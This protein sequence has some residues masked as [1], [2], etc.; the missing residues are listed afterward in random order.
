MNKHVIRYTLGKMIR[1]EGL[2]M[3][4]PALVGLIYR[5]KTGFIYLGTGLVI[6]VLGHFLGKNKPKKDIIYPREGFLIVALA[7]LVL[8]FFGAFPFYLTKEIPHFVDAFFEIVSGFTITGS[9]ILIDIEALSHPALFWR[10]FSHWIGGMGILVFVVAFLRDAP[11]TTMNILKAEMPGPIVGKLVSK[12]TD[13]TR[14]LYILYTIMTILQVILLMLGGM[15]F[16]DS[17]LNSFGTAG[18]GGFAIKNAS[19]AYYN[20]AY[21]DG[22][23]TVFMILFGINFNVFYLMA[24]RKF[25]EAFKCEEMRWYLLIIAVSVGLITINITSMYHSVIK[26]FRFASFQVASIITTTGYATADFD[27]WPLFS[28]TILVLLMFVGACAG[29]TGGGMKV[30]RIVIYIKNAFAEMKHLVHPHSIHSI[31]FENKPIHASMIN[32]IHTY[33]VLYFMIFCSSLLIV[34]LQ[35]IDFTSSFTAVATCLNNVGP[36]LSL[37]GPTSNFSSLSDLSKLVLSFDMLAGRLEIFPML[38]I[39]SKTLWKR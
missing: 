34:G 4:L 7:W 11:G 18:T 23:I 33:M 16:F 10:S 28:K 13:T 5:E 1:I 36:G 38:M 35:N 26:A 6:F 12:T 27:K 15:S 30:S 17:L 20:N 24:I 2:L 39:F 8:S 29:S 22:V 37:V 32:N 25:K 3:L 31:R 19:I 14:L 9:S 21:F